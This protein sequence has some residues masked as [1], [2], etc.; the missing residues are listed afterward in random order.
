M[1]IRKILQYYI[2]FR[3]VSEHFHAIVKHTVDSV[4]LYV[5]VHW[6]NQKEIFRRDEVT[7]FR[8]ILW[9][10]LETRNLVHKSDKES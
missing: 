1:A 10:G 4:G 3:I 6:I 2:T 5:P 9:F 7:M 8:I